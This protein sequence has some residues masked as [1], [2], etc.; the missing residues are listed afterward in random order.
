MSKFIE[1]FS[2][3]ERVMHWALVTSF[4]I[5]VL[6]GLGLYAHTFYGYFDFF[7]GPV[8]GILFHKWTAIV[9]FLCSVGLFFSHFRDLIAFDEDD[10]RWLG[11]LG[12]YLSPNG[13]GPEIPQG[14]FNAGQK[15]FGIFAFVATLVMGVTG[16]V[17]WDAAAY[18]RELTRLSLMLHGLFFTLFMVAAIVHIYLATIG[19]PGTSA[20]MLWGHVKKSWAKKHAIKWYRKVAGE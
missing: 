7:G 11:K 9:F 19:N 18:G 14:K 8:N 5:L 15:L 6:S 13:N 4:A 3:I 1:R 12:G 10:R 16:L 2:A 17:I 20:G